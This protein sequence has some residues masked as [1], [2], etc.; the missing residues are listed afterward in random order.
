MVVHE[1]SVAIVDRFEECHLEG[2]EVNA[3][4]LVSQVDGGQIKSLSSDAYQL[5]KNHTR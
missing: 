4:E 1:V 2:K 3:F 5:R